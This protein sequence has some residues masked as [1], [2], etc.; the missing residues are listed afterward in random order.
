MEENKEKKKYIIIII[1]LII[2]VL[3][4]AKSKKWTIKEGDKYLNYVYVY[5]IHAY[6]N[7][8]KIK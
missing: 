3:I 2:I 1:I 8:A 6:N 4:K 5:I 7:K